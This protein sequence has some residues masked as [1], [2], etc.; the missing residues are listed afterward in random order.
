MAS[1]WSEQGKMEEALKVLKQSM[2]KWFR[3]CE[4]SDDEKEGEDE[5]EVR[6]GGLLCRCLVQ[7]IMALP[8]GRHDN[9]CAIASTCHQHVHHRHQTPFVHVHGIPTS[10]HRQ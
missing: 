9:A 1:L 2:E 8:I 3:P 6:V 5:A 10:S 7:R 4:D